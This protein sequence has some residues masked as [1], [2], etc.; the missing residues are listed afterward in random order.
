MTPPEL[1]YVQQ[2]ERKAVCYPDAGGWRVDAYGQWYGTL[3]LIN[4]TGIPMRALRD[5]GRDGDYRP[6]DDIWTT[7]VGFDP[8]GCEVVDDLGYRERVTPLGTIEEG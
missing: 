7:W 1:E 5:N 6:E 4:M 2:R 3:K 8:S